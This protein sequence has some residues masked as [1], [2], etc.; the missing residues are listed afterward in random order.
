M[1]GVWGRLADSVE[2]LQLKKEITKKEGVMVN[3]SEIIVFF[4]LIPVLLQIVI[5]LMMLAVYI[6][7]RVMRVVFYRK[8]RISLPASGDVG[9]QKLQP[10]VT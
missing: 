10:S 4:W 8:G 2:N 5:P 7:V 9:D 6:T 1:K 3:F